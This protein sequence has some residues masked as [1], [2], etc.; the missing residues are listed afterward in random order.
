MCCIFK[1]DSSRS[2][3]GTGL[4]LSISNHII[5]LHGGKITVKSEENIGTEFTVTLTKF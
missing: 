4:G 1:I 5:D 3:P 2:E